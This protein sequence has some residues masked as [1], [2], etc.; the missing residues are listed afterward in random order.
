METKQIVAEHAIKQFFLPRERCKDLRTR[1]G[2]MPELDHTEPRIKLLDH[3]GKQSKMVI[4][5]KHNSFLVR[6]FLDYGPGEHCIHRPIA[7]PLLRGEPRL[8]I[9]VMAERPQALVCKSVVVLTSLLF[10]N[11]HP[12]ESIC[13]LIRRNHYAVVSIDNFA[14]RRSAAVRDP[15]PTRGVQQGV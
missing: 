1:P 4:L 9:G 11:P 12:P 6:G 10:R 15:D 14:I 3:A 2:D 7:F 13:G 8:S 5:D